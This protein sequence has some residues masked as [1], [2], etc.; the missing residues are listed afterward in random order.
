M[1]R[2]FKSSDKGKRVVTKD[3]DRIGTIDEIDG[4][5]AHVKPKRG[6][7]DSIR[8]RLGMESET[9]MYVLEQ[10]DVDRFTDDEVRLKN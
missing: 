9:D 5:E 8:Q 10:N 3:G 1:A 2:Q 6:L 7:A 4:N